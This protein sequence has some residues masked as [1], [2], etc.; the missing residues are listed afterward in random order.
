MKNRNLTVD[1]NWIT[2]EEVYKELD[3]VYH[4]DFDPCPYNT[5]DI[6]IDGLAVDWGRSNFVNPPYSRLLK[7]AF[8]NKGVEEMHKGNSSVFLLPVSTSTKLFHETIV[9]N[10]A[11]ITF[12]KGRIKFYKKDA[13]GNIYKTKNSGIHDSMIVVFEGL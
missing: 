8:V 2:P 5:G 11:K 4:F 12:W 7:E 3:K 10:S 6:I 13:E 1:D 9:P